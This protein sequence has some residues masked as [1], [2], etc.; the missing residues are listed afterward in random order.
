VAKRI[1]AILL[2]FL[3]GFFFLSVGGG[4]I[5]GPLLD[6][7]QTDGRFTNGEWKNS[8]VIVVLGWYGF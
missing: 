4:Y 8:G 6:S 5:P 2:I 7:L 3:I 1:T